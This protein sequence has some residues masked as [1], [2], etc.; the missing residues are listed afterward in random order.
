[1]PR[2]LFVATVTHTYA[3]KRSK[4]TIAGSILAHTALVGAVLVM[5]ILSALD[6]YVVSAHK[7][8]YTPPPVMPVKP[9]PPPPEMR[10]PVTPLNTNVAPLA[11][12]INP[13]TTEVPASTASGPP[14]PPGAD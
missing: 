6:N 10:R 3:P 9:V 12:P 13:V 14:P 11:P 4:W 5:P 1:M 2:D 7:L 8:I